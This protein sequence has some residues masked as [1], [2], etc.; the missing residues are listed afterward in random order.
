MF[1]IEY[2]ESSKILTIGGN[3]DTSKAEEAKEVLRN[4]NNSITVDMS[5]LDFICSSGIGILVMTYR[6]L[7]EIGENI[8]LVNLNDHIKKVFKLSL[9]DTVFNIK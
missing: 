1:Q 9:L 8:Y 3:F 5:N 2:N 4:I 7:K 6:R